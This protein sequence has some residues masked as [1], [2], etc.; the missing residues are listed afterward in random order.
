MV[1][2]IKVFVKIHCLVLHF[3]NFIVVFPLPFS[4]LIPPHPP[5]NHN[6]VVL[7][8]ESF[9]LFAQPLHPL[10]VPHH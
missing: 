6:T 3:L 7:V 10:T 8:H 1:L 5:G 9:F 2:C 4:P